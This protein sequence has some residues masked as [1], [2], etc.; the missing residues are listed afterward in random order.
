MAMGMEIL[1]KSMG[2]DPAQIQKD[3][4]AAM[5]A[6]LG[7]LQSINARLERIEK[8]LCVEPV[9]YL[10]HSNASPI[11]AAQGAPTPLNGRI[12]GLPDS[13]VSDE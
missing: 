11:H 6:A 1:F 2:I 3:V 10:P 13:E 9:Q 8:K 7:E 12:P 5:K 4:E